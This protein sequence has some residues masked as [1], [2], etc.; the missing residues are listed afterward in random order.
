MLPYKYNAHDFHDTEIPRNKYI[1]CNIPLS[2][3]KHI[4]WTT[5][6]DQILSVA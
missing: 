5:L 6:Q 4:H 1:S 3:G 2:L